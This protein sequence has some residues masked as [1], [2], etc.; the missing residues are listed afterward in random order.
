VSGENGNYELELLP[1]EWSIVGDNTANG[2]AYKAVNAVF[3]LS[4][5][6][7]REHCTEANKNEL[8]ECRWTPLV[9]TYELSNLVKG[10]KEITGVN[11]K[12][13]GCVSGY[14]MDEDGWCLKRT[15]LPAPEDLEASR[16]E[17]GQGVMLRW[18]HVKG[19]KEYNIYRSRA[20]FYQQKGSRAANNNIG[21]D[22]WIGTT[23]ESWF[24]DKTALPGIAYI[25]AVVA[26]NIYGESLYSYPTFGWRF[27]EKFSLGDG[28]VSCY[29]AVDFD[30]DGDGVSN[31]KE[32]E[33]NTNPCDPGSFLK[34][35]KSPAYVKYNTYL[36]QQ[37]YLE[38]ISQGSERI[39]AIVTVYDANG[40]Q[41]GARKALTI[42][43]STSMDININNFVTKHPQVGLV[44]VEYNDQD[45]GVLLNGR[46]VVYSPEEGEESVNFVATREL[47]N[48]YTGE[49]YF[50]SNTT[51][52]EDGSI[53]NENWLEVINLDSGARSFN[54]RGYDIAGNLVY[55][56]ESGLGRRNNRQGLLRVPSFGDREIAAGHEHGSGVYLI[57]VI[58]QD[59][60]TKYLASVA[61]Y[62]YNKEGQ[63]KFLM[64]APARV[65]NSDKQYFIISNHS[66]YCW[67][68]ESYLEIANVRGQNISVDF[69][70][71]NNYGQMIQSGRIELG[72]LEQQVINVGSLLEENQTGSIEL[73]SPSLGAILSQIVVEY[74]GCRDNLLQAGYNMLPSMAI[75]SAK[76]F[77]YNRFIDMENYIMIGNTLDSVAGIS[78]NVNKLQ[79]ASGKSIDYKL[80]PGYV[81][82]LDASSAP[83]RITPDNHG[84]IKIN[85]IPKHAIIGGIKRMRFKESEV[86][87]A[88]FLPALPE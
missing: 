44:R 11:F 64:V 8:E 23:S 26:V 52:S 28:M 29:E 68:E 5:N 85:S 15:K 50:I 40:K 86:D 45:S 49:G 73:Q 61:R 62:G 4:G 53:V 6:N 87:F 88:S 7:A 34:R 38:L 74:H 58:P 56:H 76:Y 37:N 65:G 77:N 78:L 17:K 41:L 12:V 63:H 75:N 27:S 47:A 35:L 32:L 46:M 14:V 72:S 13:Q 81:Y 21:F 25:Y 80:L 36:N 60:Q 20:V 67:R 31:A 48:S 19:A 82:E 1:K 55:D 51:N 33:E 54:V 84:Y 30:S 18:Q 71:R 16:G 24:E 43:P 70:V 42:E 83:L 9:V 10:R 79:F 2:K 66:G 59:G 3:D 57:K 22:D 39:Q 69:K